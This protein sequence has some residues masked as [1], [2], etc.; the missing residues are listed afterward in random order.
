MSDRDVF[1]QEHYNRVF[2]HNLN[3]EPVSPCLIGNGI[4]SLNQE[5]KNKCVNLFD[6]I[7]SSLMLFIPASGTG[8]RMFAFLNHSNLLEHFRTD[9]NVSR[10]FASIEKFA[11]WDLLPEHVKCLAKDENTL[12]AFLN[13]LLE[14]EGLNF[15]NLPKGLIPFHKYQDNILNPFEEQVVQ[16]AGI[17]NGLIKVHFTIQDKFK[18]EI[19]NSLEGILKNLGRVNIE[20]SSQ[21]TES[22]VLVFN[23]Q[24]FPCFDAQDNFIKMPGGHGAL[25]RNLNHIENDIVLIKNI[26]NVVHQDRYNESFLI[27]KEL[28]GMMFIIK[29]EAREIWENPVLANLIAFNSKYQL[30]D[31]VQL[32]QITDAD[33]IRLI[34]DRPFRICGMVKNQGEPG[35]GPFW[36][37]KDGEIS[38][39]IVEKSQIPENKSNADLIAKST[40]FNPVMMVVSNIGFNGN[41]YNLEKFADHSNFLVVEK[42]VN[43]ELI[44]FAELPG[45]WN[46]GMAYWNSVFVEVPDAVFSPVK[47]VMDLLRPEHLGH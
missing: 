33:E 5:L 44:K 20:F 17:Q 1:I 35:G 13:F 26:D 18:N 11:F 10:F 34:L 9:Q 32:S 42:Y 43:G 15:K 39:Q 19:K 27:W 8:S 21:S 6:E 7:N 16:A 4:I 37:R 41:K 40:H 12:V 47:S 38:K 45:L 25:L 24:G 36:I 2:N 29:Q 28:I 30:F 14:V 3:W 22:D 46:G 31:E 23:A